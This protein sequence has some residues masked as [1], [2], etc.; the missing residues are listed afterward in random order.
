[1]SRSPLV[2][3]LVLLISVLATSPALAVY[4]A[5]TG[6]FLQRDPNATGLPVFS[7]L[8]YNGESP[9]A[10][11]IEFD[12]MIHY[13]DGTNTYEYLRS[14]PPLYSDPLGLYVDW[15]MPGPSDMISGALESLV[16]DYTANLDW[17]ADWAADWSMNDDDHT[18]L[19]NQ[20]VTYALAYGVY[21]SYD[22]FG[23]N[24]LGEIS[25]LTLAGRRSPSPTPR[26]FPGGRSGGK[27]SHLTD[28][29]SV[30][31]GKEFTS[32]QRG[33]VL[34]ENMRQNGGRLRSD[35]TGRFLRRSPGGPNS[36]EIDHV[37][38]KSRGGSNSFANAR[39]VE[40]TW[41]RSRGNR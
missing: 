38:P 7:Q 23:F 16:H 17:D 26:S 29:P 35:V 10:P 9:G 19:E 28:G 34:E 18:R 22:I 36:A 2:H 41:N 3:L 21:E 30:G 33:R 32:S 13:R 20:W 6:R 37:I 8:A 5:S 24:L 1:M 40:R 4:S 27:Y 31:P 39:V 14:N 12:I 25:E 15:L 11:Y